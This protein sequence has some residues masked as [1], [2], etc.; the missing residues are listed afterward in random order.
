MPSI[1][2][3]EGIGAVYAA[4]LKTAGIVT[5]DTLL[6]NAATRAARE[7]LAEATGISQ[8]LILTWVERVGQAAT[9]ATSRLPRPRS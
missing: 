5:T 6:Q 7:R 2:D 8:K 4:K 9:A 3:V 1:K